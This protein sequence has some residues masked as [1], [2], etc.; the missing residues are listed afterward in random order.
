MRMSV[1][2]Y[3]VSGA[4]GV[5]MGYIGFPFTTWQFWGAVAL[6]TANGIVWALSEGDR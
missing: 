3:V 2:V 5:Y 4:F 1:W 6:F